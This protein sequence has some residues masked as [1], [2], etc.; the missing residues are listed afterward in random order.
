MLSQLETLGEFFKSVA[1]PPHL[2]TQ[3]IALNC[4]KRVFDTLQDAILSVRRD[5]PLDPRQPIFD[6]P[7]RNLQ[8]SFG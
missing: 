8:P 2:L 7:N 5:Q 6:E 4:G 1:E 3:K